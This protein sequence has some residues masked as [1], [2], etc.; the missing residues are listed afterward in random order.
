MPLDIPSDVKVHNAFDG[1]IEQ[2][3]KVI[4]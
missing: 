3:V 4:V 1:H 2:A